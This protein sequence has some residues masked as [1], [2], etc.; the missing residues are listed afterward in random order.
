[1][2]DWFEE[3]AKTYRQ[4]F[5]GRTLPVLWESA[6]QYDDRGWQME[7]LTGNYL[8]VSAIAPRPI[9]NEVSSVELAED[10]TS[11]IICDV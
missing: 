4:Q 10:G 1:L 6:T 5:V 7:G 11:R 3:S 9:W 8:R 2:H